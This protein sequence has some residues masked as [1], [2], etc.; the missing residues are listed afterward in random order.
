MSVILTAL[1]FSL[2]HH[3]FV[4]V[5]KRKTRANNSIRQNNSAI[6]LTQNRLLILVAYDIHKPSALYRVRKLLTSFA[7]SGQKS[8]Y[9]CWVTAGE[10]SHL[11]EDI[12]ERIDSAVDR[13]HF[14]ELDESHFSVFLGE[15]R[16]QSIEPFLIV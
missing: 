4:K 11:L 10:L 1:R 2:K 3:K 7:I 16:R 12:S 8:F 13:V 9:E 15:A 14:F 5:T 6:K